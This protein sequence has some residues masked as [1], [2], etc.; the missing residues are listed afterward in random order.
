LP[1]FELG[2]G[3]GAFA[4]GIAGMGGPRRSAGQARDALSEHRH[5]PRTTAKAGTE[6]R[7]A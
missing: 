4:D 7:S 5:H 1:R 3:A 2:L 6:N